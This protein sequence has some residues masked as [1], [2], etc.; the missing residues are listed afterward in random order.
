MVAPETDADGGAK[1]AARLVETVRETPFTD[2]DSA[3]LALTASVGVAVF[4]PDGR[5]A[6][7][8]MAASDRAMYAAKAAGRDRWVAGITCTP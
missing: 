5:T 2:G 4:P 8:L 3:G 6:A 7:A 1:L